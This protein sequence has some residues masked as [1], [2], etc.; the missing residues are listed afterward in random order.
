MVFWLQLGLVAVGAIL[1]LAAMLPAWFILRQSPRHLAGWRA[2]LAMIVFFF[3]GYIAFGYFLYHSPGG[4]VESIVTLV[5]L[6]GAAFVLLVM[7]MSYSTVRH[8]K[9]IAISESHRA[10][11]DELTGLPNRSL[12]RERMEYTIAISKRESGVF[13][14]LL[15]DLDRFKDVNDTLGH[16]AGDELLKRVAP[17]L[18]SLTR[19]SDTVARLGGDEFAVLLPG[20]GLTQSIVVAN[21]LAELLETPFEINGHHLNIGVSTGIC[22]YPAHGDTVEVL[23]QHADTAMYM[24]K[25]RDQSDSSYAIYDTGQ[26]RHTLENLT[27]LGELREAIRHGEFTLQYQ[28][29]IRIA[30]GRPCGVEALVR[31]NHPRHGLIPPAKFIPLA[32]QT[33]QIPALTRWVLNATFQQY[34]RWREAGWRIPVA[35]NISPRDLRDIQ[36]AEHVR[37]LLDRWQVPPADL[38]LEFTEGS[39]MDDPDRTTDV[40]SRLY[41]MGLKLSIDDFGTGYSSFSYLKQLPVPEIKIDRSFV[42]DMLHN[43]RDAVMVRSII[44][45]AHNMGLKVVAEGVETREILDL[46]EI[47]ACDQA[48]GFGIA[49]PLTPAQLEE[50]MRFFSVSGG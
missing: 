50:W 14:L 3:L 16:A 19:E 28:P 47:L 13:S 20:T 24:A 21:K 10:L 11:H 2:L 23:L 4:A 15:M 7:L 1:L 38:T 12:L 25:R 42:Q 29:K 41:G 44:N 27:L 48:Q 30:D 32:E 45:L 22:I 26:D 5:F 36:F 9:E 33:G 6:G 34:N 39:M 17:R 18:C 40:I 35:V 37:D 46:L 31:W 43:E 49:R 8:E